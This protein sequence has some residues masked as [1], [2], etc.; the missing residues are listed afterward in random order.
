M[1]RALALI[2][3]GLLCV[4]L[5]LPV[6]ATET[7]LPSDWSREAM[8]FAVENGIYYGDHTGALHP[9][10]NITRAEM[11]AV[12]VRLLGAQEAADLSAYTDVDAS[13]W[14]APELSAAVAAGI[15]SG[16]SAS[17]MQPND[18]I[19]REQAAVVFSRAFGI[20]SAER[21][22]E[23]IFSDASAVSVYARDAV[24]ALYARDI[25]HGYPDGSFRPAASITR[26]E[27]AQLLSN[28]LDCIADTPDELPANGTVLYRG[29]AALPETLTL[30]GTL[31]LGQAMPA[32]FTV[33][34]WS[35]SD[36]LVLRT[37]S[38]TDLDLTNLT[39]ETLVCAPNGGSVAAGTKTVRL[40][41]SVR[42]TGN[43]D[44][45]TAVSGTHSAA[46]E[47]SAVCVRGGSLTLDG[48]A[49]SVTLESA[50]LTLNGTADTVVIDGKNARLDG[51]GHVK[52]VTVNEENAD[53]SVS[54]DTLVDEWALRYQ[55]EHGAALTTVR[56][57][58]IPC[59]VLYDT[60]IY[61]N[62]DY[63]GYIR[64]LPKGTVV[65]NEYHPD[66]AM[67]ITCADGTWGW[68]DSWACSI[69]SG[70]TTDGDLD[71][72]KATKE[73]YVDLRGY[74]S[75]TPYLIWVSRYT[76]KVMVFHGSKGDWELIHTFPCSS[77]SNSTPTPIGVFEI[78]SR[79][80]LWYFATYYVKNASSFNGGHAFHTI[81]YNYDNSVLDGR[82]GQPL[83]HGCVR[84]HPADCSYI[85]SLPYRTRVVIY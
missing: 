66:R 62:R 44:T 70:T 4:L 49:K 18:P 15:F 54:Y 48:T 14:Y 65:Y 64:T 58:R 39:A 31:I 36:T 83:S 2:L 71:Y 82:V 13:A 59:T 50:V 22:V 12:L 28:L 61:E 7:V 73:G 77:G 45:L 24:S 29:S 25:L 38:D 37:G 74:E 46:G 43:A 42:Y 5:C 40:M 57:A 21:N 11:A 85:Y 84:M 19:T 27:V 67:H 33:T 76:Q 60:A 1:K 63:T 23:K 6:S 75:A 69:T 72:S 30:D 35:I 47:Y 17:R 52:S 8:T 68:I 3:A 55:N 20:V 80:P 81:T 32:R 16:V 78:T 41:G 9:H 26:A 53:V 51:S 10:E 34:A 79:D 56:T